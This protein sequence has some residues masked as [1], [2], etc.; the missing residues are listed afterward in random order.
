[1]ASAPDPFL[2]DKLHHR[3]TTRC[4]KSFC[5]RS[6]AA[7]FLT[8]RG[9]RLNLLVRCSASRP[10]AEGIDDHSTR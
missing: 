6:S 9:C 4:H 10:I 1:M 2:Q 3:W 7:S 5:G 8:S